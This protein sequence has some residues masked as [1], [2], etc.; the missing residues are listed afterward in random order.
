MKVLI[1]G[2][3]GL[4]GANFAKY[5][6][7]LDQDIDIIGLDN[8]SGGYIEN[9]PD[10]ITFLKLNLTD[11]NDQKQLIQHFPV[12]YIF[13]FAAYAAE[14]L[15]PFIRQYN[16]TN[17]VI[18]TSF[19]I[20]LGIQY[21]I[22]RFI[23]TSS[24]A[25]YGNGEVPFNESD[26]PKPIDPYGVAK[27]CCEMDLQ[28]AYDQHGL[29]FSIIRPHNVY[30]PLQNIW[31]PYRNVLGIWMLNAYEN[32]PINIYGDGEQTRAF[33][34]IDDILPC[35][36]NAALYE[37][38]KNEI[39]NLG[40]IQS[41]SLNDIATI[42]CKITNKNDICHL[43]KRHEVKHAWSTYQKSIDILDYKETVSL[44][45]GL[46]KMWEWVNT[47]PKRD[48]I[49]WDKYEIDKDIYSYWKLN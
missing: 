33:S 15:S 45:D 34:Y 49:Y 20:N 18:A 22:K 32:K 31:D 25:V 42:L 35:I 12:D 3:A 40:G 36:W 2:C 14:G 37:K 19:L 28:I 8:L 47:C 11:E 23:F 16:Y 30:G 43:E 24:M 48:K 4:I 13:H 5:L 26:T 39:V 17:N 46:T 41:I 6:L 9:V 38:A 1:T 10:N 27:Y 44:E 7:S 29:E 21:S